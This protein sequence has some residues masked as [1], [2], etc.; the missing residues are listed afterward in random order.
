[1]QRVGAVGAATKALTSLDSPP[2]DWVHLAKGMGVAH[3][4]AA[5]TV[6]EFERQLGEA[7]ARPGPSLI[8]ALL[9]GSS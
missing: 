2:I 4:S 8:E 7:L 6:G 1:M 3:A 9:L 5:A